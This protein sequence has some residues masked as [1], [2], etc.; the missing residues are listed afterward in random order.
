MA[1]GS[2]LAFALIFAHTMLADAQGQNS[3][4]QVVNGIEVYL[5]VVPAEMVAGHPRNS[6]ERR[7]HGGATATGG[8]H[9]LVALFDHATGKRITDAQVSA[10][11]GPPSERASET[12]L[13]PMTIAGAQNYGNYLNM[14]RGGMYRIDVQI[15]RPGSADPIQATFHWSTP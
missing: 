13:E 2:L 4:Q 1:V 7:M 9:V 3:L 14:V 5:G 11:L 15:R 8:H 12:R 10:R 6:P